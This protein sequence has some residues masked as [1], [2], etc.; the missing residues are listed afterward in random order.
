MGYVKVK[1]KIWNVKN[2]K[3]AKKLELLADPEAVYTVLPKS[4]LKELNLEELGLQVDPVK[5]ELKPLELLLM[6]IFRFNKVSFQ[7]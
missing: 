1:T 6:N 7:I 3:L 2:P 4:L 5:G